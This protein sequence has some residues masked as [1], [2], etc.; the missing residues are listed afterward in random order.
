MDAFP[1]AKGAPAEVMAKGVDALL[2][3]VT[4]GPSVD[5]EGPCNDA[6]NNDFNLENSN[7]NWMAAFAANNAEPV[8]PVGPRHF[9]ALFG[10]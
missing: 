9:A 3:H 1:K 7:S 8:V 5:V 10:A 6:D 4:S 2:Q